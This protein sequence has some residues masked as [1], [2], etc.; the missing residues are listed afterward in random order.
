M[1][2]Q[3]N[4]DRRGVQL[5]EQLHRSGSDIVPLVVP[6]DKSQDWWWSTCNHYNERG[7]DSHYTTAHMQRPYKIGSHDPFMTQ[8]RPQISTPKW[9][10]PLGMD[11]LPMAPPTARLDLSSQSLIRKRRRQLPEPAAPVSSP[12]G[13]GLGMNRLSWRQTRAQSCIPDGRPAHRKAISQTE[14]PHWKTPGELGALADL[15]FVDGKWKCIAR[16]RGST[17]RQEES[18]HEISARGQP[19]E[20]ASAADKGLRHSEITQH[21]R[22]VFKQPQAYPQSPRV[23]LVA[24]VQA[25]NPVHLTHGRTDYSSLQNTFAAL[26]ESAKRSDSR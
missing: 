5:P 16:T 12:T 19:L 20:Y 15:K 21:M 3:L 23:S 1:G 2:V 7:M 9:A 11:A 8:Q 6:C 10:P 18:L 13:P 25:P 17:P 26:H 22:C 4:Q 24:R 14:P